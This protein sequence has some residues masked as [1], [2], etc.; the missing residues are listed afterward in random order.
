M[1]YPS[2]GNESPSFSKETLTHQH[3]NYPVD[4]NK[5]LWDQFRNIMNE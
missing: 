4:N 5:N 2:F 1:G 3:D